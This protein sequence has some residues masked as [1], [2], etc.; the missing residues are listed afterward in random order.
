MKYMIFASVYI[1]FK[2]SNHFLDFFINFGLR[3][4]FLEGSFLWKSGPMRYD[5]W[6][7]GAIVGLFAK[8]S[9]FLIQKRHAKG[10]ALT[11]AARSKIEGPH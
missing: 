9:G 11:S 8:S 10:Y 7:Q 1:Y 6:T 2:T 4:L 5:L 3:L